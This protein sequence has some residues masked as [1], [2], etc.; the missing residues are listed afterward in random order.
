MTNVILGLIL[1]F[2][3]LDHMYLHHK[4]YNERLKKAH[5]RSKVSALKDCIKDW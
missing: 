1:F 3:L 2:A 4:K 5:N